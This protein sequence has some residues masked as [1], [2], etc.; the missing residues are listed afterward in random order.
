MLSP[1][2]FFI[3]LKF[4]QMEDGAYALNILPYEPAE[5]HVTSKAVRG[6]MNILQVIKPIDDETCS[7]E[8]FLEMDPKGFI[9]K[10][11]VN[12]FVSSH[13]DDLIKWRDLLNEKA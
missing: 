1:R 11:I 9:P 2:E 4:Y 8:S 3:A 6:T 10:W 13:F 12:Y 7:S 5:H